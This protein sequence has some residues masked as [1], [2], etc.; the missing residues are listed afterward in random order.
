MRSHR[1]HRS[2]AWFFVASI[3]AGCLN[4]SAP[5][6]WNFRILYQEN[7]QGLPFAPVGGMGIYAYHVFDNPG[8]VVGSSTTVNGNTNFSG[9]VYSTDG[10][11]P[12]R[13]H[14][15]MTS[16]HCNGQWGEQNVIKD[17]TVEAFCTT[18]RS[19]FFSSNSYGSLAYLIP[20][21]YWDVA[22]DLGTPS[23]G[24]A[25]TMSQSANL[26]VP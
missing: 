11:V 22:S 13:W 10:R 25:G 24:D 3:C 21:E 20:S 16:G 8:T 7:L 9:F 5:E 14:I 23:P 12:A 18:T 15:A 26:L 17:E 6:T 4:V 1:L 2:I 19:P